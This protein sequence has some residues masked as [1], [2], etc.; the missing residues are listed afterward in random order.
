MPNC[1]PSSSASAP[2]RVEW[3]PSRWLVAAL[4]ILSLLAPLSV[5]GAEVPRWLAWPLALAAAAWGLR[6]AWREAGRAP[7]WLVLA[8]RATGPGD[9]IASHAGPDTLDGRPL[10]RCEIAW[11][12]PLAFVHAVD[13]AGRHQRLTWWPDTLPA[14]R[15]RELRLAAAARGAS[16]HGRPMAP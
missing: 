4:L 14:A 1:P 6:L 3:R 16:R 8:D 15:R 10:A 13:D 7:R 5:L 12:G 11:R 2:C 9:G